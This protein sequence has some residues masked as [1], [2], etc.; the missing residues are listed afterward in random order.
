MVAVSI[1]FCPTS[2]VYLCAVTDT[3]SDDACDISSR[4]AETIA[5]NINVPFIKPF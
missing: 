5:T 1:E 3:V 4:S 2:I